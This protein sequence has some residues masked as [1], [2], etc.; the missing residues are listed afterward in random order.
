MP[1]APGLGLRLTRRQGRLRRT[2]AATAAGHALDN[3]DKVCRLRL[4]SS[5]GSHAS[6]HTTDGRVAM[7]PNL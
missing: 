1:R 7:D 4:G 2:H 6:H 3:L 5:Q